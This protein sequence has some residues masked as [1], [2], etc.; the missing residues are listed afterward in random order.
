MC[1]LEGLWFSE[2]RCWKDL[3]RQ[4]GL[5]LEQSSSCRTS[6]ARAS[7][8]IFAGRNESARRPRTLIFGFGYLDL[9]LLS[10]PAKQFYWYEAFLRFLWNLNFWNPST[11][12]SGI[13]VERFAHW[14]YSCC[15][16]EDGSWKNRS[17]V[18]GRTGAGEDFFFLSFYYLGF[19][20]FCGEKKKLWKG[21]RVFHLGFEEA[22]GSLLF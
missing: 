17:I 4:N 16:E 21:F 7:L 19:S 9:H 8:R 18:R 5:D 3:N 11:F 1:C 10:P 6:V 12:E 15:C 2:G 20:W 13:R 22:G 14:W